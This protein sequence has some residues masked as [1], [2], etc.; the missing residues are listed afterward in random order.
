[1]K[2]TSLLTAFLATSVLTACPPPSSGP[3]PS[4]PVVV[5]DHRDEP[6]PP[7][8]GPTGPVWDSSGW[9][10]LGSA[11]VDGARD[12]DTIQ[13]GRQEGRFDVITMVV[14][15]SDL[16]LRDFV[17]TFENN[18]KFE[19]HTQHFFRE[20]ARTRQIDLPAKNRAIKQID[21]AYA[22]IPGGGKA[23]V[24]IYGKDVKGGG[25]G[26]GG[27]NQPPP[28]VDPGPPPPPVFDNAGWTLLGSQTVEGKKDSD[29]FPVGKQAGRFDQI[30]I[31]V[32]DSDLEMISFVVTFENNKK[33][34]PKMKQ[35]FK[36]GTRTR[37]IDLPEKNRA[38]KEIT[39]KYAN[40]P[41]GGKAKVEIYARDTKG[42]GPT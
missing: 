32:T 40:L 3:G 6:P 38:I 23:R 5:R 19:P 24:E 33:F 37:V 42:K 25:G 22:N 39:V 36:E 41:G 20:G 10:L 1:M 8:P 29:V 4:E 17:V 16:E 35:F 9:T 21:L 18:T 13:V 30:T 12:R 28:P 14:T 27:G 15:D 34:D 2:L 7:P 31:V 26:G 11:T